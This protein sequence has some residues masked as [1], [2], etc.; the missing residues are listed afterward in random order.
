MSVR[1]LVFTAAGCQ[2]ETDHHVSL[3]DL[4]RSDEG[5]DVPW[6]RNTAQM[7]PRLSVRQG[8]LRLITP[9]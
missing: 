7:C 9:A 4:E 3:L 8:A 6:N 2:G 5:R 1:M